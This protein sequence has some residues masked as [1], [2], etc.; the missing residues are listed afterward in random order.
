MKKT[1]LYVDDQTE[2]HVVFRAAFGRMFKVLK[3]SCAD[4]ALAILG[5]YEIPVVVA[6]QRMPGMTGVELF[7]TVKVRYPHTI[8]I[9][10]T[11]HNDPEAM[12]DAINKGHVYS[13]LTKPWK[14][15][16]LL[17]TLI[18]GFEAYDLVMSNSALTEQLTH[19]E[20][21]AKLGQHAAKIAHEMGNQLCV[22]PL[23]QWIEDQ[24]GECDDLLE[25]A[26]I[27]KETQDRLVNLI[28]EIKSFVRGQH[29]SY[30]MEEVLL[31]HLLSETVSFAR[32][33]QSFP[34]DSIR[35]VIR[36]EPSASVNSPKIQ[37]ALLNLLLNAAY[38]V[39]NKADPMITVS[40]EECENE[41]L[42]TVEDNGSGIPSDSLAKIWEPFFSTKGSSGTGLGLD[43]TRRII[44]VHKGNI[45]CTSTEG[46]GTKFTISLP[47]ARE[48][49]A[50]GAD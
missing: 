2:N 6:D 45:N 21:C 43:I 38:A 39:Q 15:E 18:R 25:L 42:I 49:S 28:E 16:A 44:E 32:F 7:E 5:Q 35:L 48:T 33:D 36:D 27:A 19:A 26:S 20:R 4:E 8:R 50:C 31:D 12:M 23:V 37:Q 11:G 40:L 30:A 9:I 22:T 29:E 47:M 46:V 41:A 14:K 17:S 34:K 13:F 1:L 3:A 24:Y 10:L